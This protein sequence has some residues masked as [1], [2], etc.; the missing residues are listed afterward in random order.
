MSFN[1][2]QHP[3][4]LFLHPLGGIPVEAERVILHA[5]S[6]LLEYPDKQWNNTLVQIRN[7]REQ[8]SV[9]SQLSEIWQW[10][11]DFLRWADSTNEEERLH[12]Y[13]HLFDFNKK[14]TL[15]MTYVR[16]G[17]ERERGQ[18]LLSLKQIYEE[19]GFSMTDKELSDFLPL[20]LEFAAVAEP[21]F[22]A[23][24]IDIILPGME[25]LHKELKKTDTP[26][27]HL[28]AAALTAS[29]RMRRSVKRKRF[30]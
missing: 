8:A 12:H 5:V 17:E 21:S 20:V 22:A 25:T 23:C 16:Y 19:A 30:G 10:I 24:A 29:D 15:Y 9:G 3:G 18:A 27:A 11:D 2:F 14:T 4:K 1:G 28:T 6:R 13:I 26:Y 7:E